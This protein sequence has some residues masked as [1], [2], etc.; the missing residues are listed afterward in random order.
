MMVEIPV[1]ACLSLDHI[2]HSLKKLDN[3]LLFMDP[4]TEMAVYLS[5]AEDES[6][7]EHLEITKF[8]FFT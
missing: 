2:S 6:I 8:I 5:D 7:T 4:S 3:G 1:L